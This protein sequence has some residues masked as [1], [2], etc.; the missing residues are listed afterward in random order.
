MKILIT[1]FAGY[2]LTGAVHAQSANVKGK[3]LAKQI[4]V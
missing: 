1:F 4:H 3:V 2:I